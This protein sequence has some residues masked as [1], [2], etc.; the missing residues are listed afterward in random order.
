MGG[1]RSMN[2]IGGM[3]G[4]RSM[5]MRGGMHGSAGMRNLGRMGGSASMRNL[6]GMGGGYG[7]GMGD[8]RAMGM[9]GGMR[10]G[11]GGYDS[12]A[13]RSPHDKDS[14]TFGHE[15]GRMA[16]IDH[17]ERNIHGGDDIRRRPMMRGYGGDFDSDGPMQSRQDKDFVDPR[18]EN[19]PYGEVDHGEKDNHEGDRDDPDKGFEGTGIRPGYFGDSF[20][21]D[22]D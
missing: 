13:G 4:I 14:V 15:N 5:G 22:G 6:G 7:G 3:G 16:G 8:I 19:G 20:D 21:S 11:L 12:D 1:I 10:G 2:G 18:H 9:R 17:G